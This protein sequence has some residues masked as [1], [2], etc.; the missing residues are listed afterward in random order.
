MI[1][2]ILLISNRLDFGGAEVYVV[3]IANRLVELGY[4]VHV[5]SSGGSLVEELSNDVKHFIIP[6]ASKKIPGIIKC[7]LQLRKILKDNKIEIIHSNSV[8][9]CLIS[10]LATLFLS[11]PIINTVHS[12]GTSRKPISAAIVNLC[13]DNVVA[14]SN[15]T[16]ESYISHGLNKKKVVVVHNGIDTKR[17]T[18]L[19]IEDNFKNREK[20][21]LKPEDFVVINIARMEEVRKG[22]NTLLDAA[23]IVVKSY[24]NCKFLLAGDGNLRNTLQDKVK[25]FGIENN[26]IFLGNRADVVDLLSLSDIFCLP[27]DWEGLPLVIAEAMSCGLPVIAT[28]VNGVPEIVL[29]KITG[30]LVQPQNPEQLSNKILELM[31]N[32]DLKEKMSAASVKRTNETFSLDNLI[33]RLHTIYS[34]YRTL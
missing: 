8:I 27:S 9:T 22:H 6:A 24:S 31:Q 15:S 19:S 23:N 3:S 12:W 20:L 18:R 2:N 4:N 25:N 26:V 17:F 34:Q 13:A 1:K 11:I 16:A 7:S 33:K 28:A 14:V 5:A 21:G 29:D 30:Y 32:P 10:K